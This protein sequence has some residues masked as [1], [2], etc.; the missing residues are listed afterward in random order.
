MKSD[1]L[2]NIWRRE[3]DKINDHLPRNYKTLE[4]LLSSKNPYVITLDGDQI[5]FDRKE[6]EFLAE[7]VPKK[8]HGSLQLPIVFIRR[9]EMGEG[10]YSISGGKIEKGVIMKLLGVTENPFS[11]D[12]NNFPPYIYRHQVLEIRR[13]IRSLTTIGFA[14]TKTNLKD[15][16]FKDRIV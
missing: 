16:V 11:D 6:L 4:S 3:I 8:Y 12:E 9:I 1:H 5:P 2:S 14:T 10:V 15:S 7:I 13:K